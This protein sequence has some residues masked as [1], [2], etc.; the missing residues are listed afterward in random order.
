MTN[1]SIFIWLPQRE[2]CPTMKGSIP[3]KG[4]LPCNKVLCGRHDQP[5]AVQ[6]GSSPHNHCG[7]FR[8]QCGASR[9]PKRN[10]CLV[11]L[12]RRCWRRVPWDRELQWLAA[13]IGRPI[14]PWM[15]GVWQLIWQLEPGQRS[16]ASGRAKMAGSISWAA[17]VLKKKDSYINYRY[18]KQ[19]F[20]AFTWA[21]SSGLY[22][23]LIRPRRKS[24][25]IT[26]VCVF[27]AIIYPIHF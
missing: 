18:L 25:C 21:D 23:T 19:V 22:Q 3:C 13:P 7:I 11:S 4:V 6:I 17:L 1:R 8:A 9:T 2:V 5:V 15:R 26:T 10:V 16:W 20:W 27:D 24:G 14:N 12:C